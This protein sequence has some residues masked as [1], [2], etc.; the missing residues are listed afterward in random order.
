MSEDLS[1]YEQYLDPEE[2]KDTMEQLAFL[3]QEQIDAEREVDL[4]EKELKKAKRLLSDISE[5]QIPDLM[6][7]LNMKSFKL[8]T[9]ESIEVLEKLRCSIAGERNAGAINW[10]D[11]NNHGNL[12]KRNYTIEFDRDEKEEAEKFVAAMREHNRR[13]R[14]SQKNT[15]HNQ[16]LSS[17]LTER[18]TAGDD[19]PM[20]LFGAYWQKKTKIKR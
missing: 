15:V 16:T 1:G 4:A 14:I 5:K 11:E 19:I 6:A 18:L 2:D 12:V 9:G 7:K 17:F 3:A 8:M 13:L 10:L 20:D